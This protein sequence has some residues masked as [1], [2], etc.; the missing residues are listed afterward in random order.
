[1]DTS[2]KYINMC[3]KATKIHVEKP[4]EES[5][6]AWFY[7]M[8]HNVVWLPT[9][10]ELYELHTPSESNGYNAYGMVRMFWNWL[11]VHRKYTHD[12]G[13][14]SIEQHL[15]AFVM[16]DIFGERWDGT[17]WEAV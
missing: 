11:Y 15:L 3:L 5:I 1:M 13:F 7:C 17:E 16:W 10:A 6:R 9:Q 14:D 2:K 4:S 12:Q 8:G